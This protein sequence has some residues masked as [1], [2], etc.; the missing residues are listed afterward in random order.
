MAGQHRLV[1]LEALPAHLQAQP[2]SGR[3]TSGPGQPKV[4][5]STSVSSR[6]VV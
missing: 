5:S 2:V 1:G 6:L 3:R 4:A